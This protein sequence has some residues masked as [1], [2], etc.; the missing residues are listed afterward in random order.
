M[1]ID[2]LRDDRGFTLVELLVASVCTVIVLGGAVA[3]AGQ[4]QAGYR[5]QIED[6][7]GEQEGRYALEWINR[8]LRSVGN[9]PFNVTISN[10]P[11]SNTAFEGLIPDSTS[12]S[13]LTIQSDSNPPD[14]LIGGTTGNCTEANEHVT[15]SFDDTTHTI[16]FQDNASAATTRTDAVIDGLE[17]IYYTSAKE[18]WPDHDPNPSAPDTD[19]IFYVQTNITLRTRT[20]DASTGGPSTRT[21]SSIVRVRSR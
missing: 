15:I 20:V 4:V 14:G 8:Y 16:Q 1:R 12:S 2:H 17:F 6:S 18:T 5:R 7:V 11:S 13:T 19:N 3:I 9:N 10:C 21:L